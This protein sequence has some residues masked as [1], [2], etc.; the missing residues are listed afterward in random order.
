MTVESFEEKMNKYTNRE[1]LVSHLKYLKELEVLSVIK[2]K[3]KTTYDLSMMFLEAVE[4]L[5]PGSELEKKIIVNNQPLVLMYNTIAAKIEKHDI[6]N[7]TK[8]FK[9]GVEKTKVVPDDVQIVNSYGSGKLIETDSNKK[10][11][12]KLKDFDEYV[13]KGR[14]MFGFKMKSEHHKIAREMIKKK[15]RG[16]IKTILGTDN[17]T[18]K[19]CVVS[20]DPDKFEI[21][22]NG[23]KDE[24]IFKI[25]KL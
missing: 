12:L 18:V 4:S 19:S 2:P 11:R 3:G 24:K 9:E 8:N 13:Y 22:T 21:V 15:S 5:D 6:E 14:D 10:K 20:I 7:M 16:E 1:E 17:K 25:Y 23:V